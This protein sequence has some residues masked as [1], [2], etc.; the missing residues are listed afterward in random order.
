MGIIIGLHL[1]LVDVARVIL[2]GI[3]FSVTDQLANRGGLEFA[4]LDTIGRALDKDYCNRVAMHEAGHFLVAYLMG[5]LPRAYT[6]SA[7]DAVVRYKSPNVQAGCVFCDTAFQKE[8]AN[9]S[10]TRKSLD[11]VVCVA[12]G[13][14]AAEFLLFGQSKGGLSDVQQL[15]ALFQALGFDQRRASAQL[16]WAVL[17]VVGLLRKHADVHK[18]LAKA[19]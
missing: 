15:E 13:G 12:L 18:A 9:G 14:V 6:L 17:N 1:S 8:V 3:I 16:R 19:M 7:L 5:V 11:N 4:I 10:I 2:A